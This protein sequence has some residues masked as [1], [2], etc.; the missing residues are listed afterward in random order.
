VLGFSKLSIL[1]GADMAEQTLEERQKVLRE[2]EDIQNTLTSAVEKVARLQ[3]ETET[4]DPGMQETF[5]GCVSSLSQVTE[6][7]QTVRSDYEMETARRQNEGE[8]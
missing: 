6:Q 7:I 1:K 8:L 2:L 4:S 5:D 3:L